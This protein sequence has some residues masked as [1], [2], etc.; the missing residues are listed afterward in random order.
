MEGGHDGEDD[1]RD[2]GIAHE[3]QV[4]WGGVVVGHPWQDTAGINTY[5]SSPE[6]MSFATSPVLYTW[7][8][9]EMT[10]R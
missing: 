10:L 1:D 3:N 7:T 6:N 2:Q 4:P 5:L 9:S 8:I